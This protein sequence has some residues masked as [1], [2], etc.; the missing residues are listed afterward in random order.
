M[1]FN[2]KTAGRKR[3]NLAI[4][5]KNFH[6]ETILVEQAVFFVCFY[7]PPQV[8]MPQAPSNLNRLKAFSNCTKNGPFTRSSGNRWLSQPQIRQEIIFRSHIQYLTYIHQLTFR[9]ISV[10][11]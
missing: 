5:I 7:I 6:N 9:T 10:K 2:F 4:L 8:V 3:M 1:N 11:K